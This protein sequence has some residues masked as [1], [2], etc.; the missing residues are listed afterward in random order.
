M[1]KVK[2]YVLSQDDLNEDNISEYINTYHNIRTQKAKEEINE[3]CFYLIV[4][5]YI[6]LHFFS[7]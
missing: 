1:K 5:Y 2:N 3:V 4:K 6:Y 7:L